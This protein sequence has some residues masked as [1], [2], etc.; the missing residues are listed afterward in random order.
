MVSRFIRSFF[1]FVTR[2]SFFT[3]ANKNCNVFQYSMSYSVYS[4]SDFD[5]LL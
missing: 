5:V 1:Y 3:D 4:F 2:Q